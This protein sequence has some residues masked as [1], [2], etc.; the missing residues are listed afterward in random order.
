M[1][2][3]CMRSEGLTF[4]QEG[5]ISEEGEIVLLHTFPYSP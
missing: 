5:T 3:M 2:A 4:S 1:R